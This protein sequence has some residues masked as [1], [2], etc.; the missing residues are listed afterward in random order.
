[1]EKFMN[2]LG[3][4]EVDTLFQEPEGT[5]EEETEVEGNQERKTPESQ[6][7]NDETTTTEVKGNLFE[8]DDIQ[9]PESVGSEDDI[10]G[11]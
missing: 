1:M 8:G 4:D 5:T 3:A 7:E 2:I 6:E 9:E 11:G 10:Q